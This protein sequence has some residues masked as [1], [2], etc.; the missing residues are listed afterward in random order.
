MDR[1][2]SLQLNRRDLFKLSGGILLGSVGALRPSWASAQIPIEAATTGCGVGAEPFPTSPFILNPFTD[3][4][5]IPEPLA[6]VAKSMVDT[7]ASPPGSGPGQQDYYG[8]THQLWP[9]T[10]AA[11]YNAEPLI[12]QIKL[13]VSTHKFTSSF[14]QPIDK[15]GFAVTA[16]GFGPGPQK[17]PD[18]TIYGYNGTFPG[19]M[20]YARYGQ[21][22]LVRFEN[23]LDVGNGL[24]RQ[25]FGAPDWAFLTH[26]HNGHTAP[27]SDGN[28]HYMPSAYEPGMWCDNLYLNYPAGGDDTEKQSFFWFHDHRMDHTGA[29]VYKGMVGLYPIYDP[30]L[31]PGDE[32]IATGL[33]L[34]GVPTGVGL[35]GQPGSTGRVEYDIPL[36]FYDCRLDD[37]VTQHQ[38]FHNGC[39]E[40][41]PE[42]WGKT[43]F[44]HYPNHGFVGDVFTVNCTAYPV[45]EV[46]RRKYRFRCL[47]AS[48]ARVYEFVLMSST[49]GPVAAPGVQGQY[50]LPDGQQSMQFTEIAVDGGLLPAPIVRNAFELWPAKRREVV[51]DFTKYMD[52]TPTKKGDVVYLVNVKQ[53]TNGRKPNA[54]ADVPETPGDPFFVPFD[55][56]YRVPMLKFVI[57]DLPPVPDVSVIPSR[58]RPLP[59]MN[60]AVVA[61]GP[62]REFVLQRGGSGGGES[63][64]L[65]NGQ[66][67]DPTVSLAAARRGVPEVWTI[68]NGGG[69]WVHPLHLHMEEHQV[70]TRNGIRT[71]LDRKHPDDASRE[72][73]VA[74]EPGES[75]VVYRNFRTFVG[76]YVAHC[77]NLAHEDHAMMF[78]W[79]IIE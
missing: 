6:P 51:V 68:R 57:G 36:A 60:A 3:P 44:R 72:D 75:V 14:V 79:D 53:M 23:H 35:P 26:L 55:P 77:H 54:A 2:H 62:T 56:N 41:H 31:D 17:L 42:W 11:P 32:R 21:P 7:W 43:F 73:V 22:S 76:P 52:G 25:D 4:L 45:L 34:P 67:F 63:E 12:Y 20:I 37:G 8:G 40:T 19:P 10:L 29:N 66:I 65:I 1:R 46:K 64:W 59:T 15:D 69:G 49:C 70:L 58:L 9:S 78:G 50:Q 27:E 5:P 47:D 61:G 71:P 39:G 33:R 28:P 16:P 30:K 48:I 18:S 13:E 74:L 24:D 38:D